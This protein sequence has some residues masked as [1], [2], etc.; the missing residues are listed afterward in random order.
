MDSINRI[1]RHIPFFRHCTARELG[2]LR[3]LGRNVLISKGQ[4][5]DLKK[6][7]SFIIVI[8]GMFEIEALGKNDIVYLAPG[9]FFGDI[10]FTV[11]RHRGFIKALVDSQLLLF[12]G[13]EI[14]KFFLG[15]FKGMRGFLRIIGK[16]GFEITD[17]GKKYAGMKCKIITVCSPYHDSGKS[18]F[19][20]L[21]AACCGKAGKTI[22]LDMSFQGASVF[23]NFGKK[24]TGAVSQKF[25]REG[26][27]EELIRDRIEAVDENLSLLNITF[28]S[29]IKA[30]PGILSPLLFILS[31]TFNYIII[32]L[33]HQDESLRDRVMEL[34]DIVFALI[35]KEKDSETLFGYFDEVLKEGQRVYYTLNQHYA[36]KTGTYEG[37][38]LFENLDLDREKSLYPQLR[39]YS[40]TESGLEL[41]QVTTRSGRALVCETN[42][43]DAVI[44]TG[45]FGAIYSTELRVDALY[46]SS[47]SFYPVALYL[48]NEDLD[49]Y[50]DAVLKFFSEARLNSLLDVTFPSEY[51]IK[52]HRAYRYAKELAGDRRIE[53]FNILPVVKL[54]GLDEG[55]PRLFSSG[56][57]RELLS[58]SFALDPVAESYRIGKTHYH[59][60]YPFS[61]VSTEDLLRT[62]IEELFYFGVKNRL[63]L[64]FTPNRV[65]NFY[66]RYL[67]FLDRWP[68]E[69]SLHEAATRHMIIEINEDRFRVEKILEL[70]RE[71]SNK[72]LKA[73]KK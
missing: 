2:D 11:N 5:F 23:N 40:E 73:I 55:R 20:S 14:Y 38:F 48:L 21:L 33:S 56:Y 62:D 39:E 26:S 41:S 22:V 37:G 10:P 6:L 69:E 32:D 28:G 13:S 68:S 19:T 50:E 52:N 7:G 43:K 1:L 67:G 53:T 29:R 72:F 4:T 42:V 36:R 12:E 57:L 9:S 18:L 15:S 8:N 51:V 3:E 60:G 44:L 49:D 65:L 47:L 54:A 63:K 24:I 45:L 31:R 70:T 25:H 71:I 58:A 34:S 35:K 16:M 46:S 17:V 66:D 64:E 59:S 30:D 27:T 61:R